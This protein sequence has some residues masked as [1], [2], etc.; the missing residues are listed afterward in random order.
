MKPTFPSIGI[1]GLI[2]VPLQGHM[3]VA[4]SVFPYK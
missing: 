3:L 2:F 4:I 1:G